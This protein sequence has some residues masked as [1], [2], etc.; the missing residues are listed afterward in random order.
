MT[1]VESGAENLETNFAGKGQLPHYNRNR[2]CF[3]LL[4]NL[5]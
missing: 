5:Y 4:Y 3:R 1:P 2:A